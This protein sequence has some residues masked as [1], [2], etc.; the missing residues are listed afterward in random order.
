MERVRALIA[1]ALQY[2]QNATPRERRLVLLA[3]AG[4][5]VF[6]LLLSLIH[7]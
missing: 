1:D 3:G 5:L 4:L 7:I 6:V 2:V